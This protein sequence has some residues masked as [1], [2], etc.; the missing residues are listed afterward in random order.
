MQVI[1]FS[2]KKRINSRIIKKIIVRIKSNLVIFGKKK[3]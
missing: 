1:K 3:N 2:V